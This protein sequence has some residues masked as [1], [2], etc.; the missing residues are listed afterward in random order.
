MP[1]AWFLAPGKGQF[2][3]EVSCRSWSGLWGVINFDIDD[4]CSQYLEKAS[5]Y[6]SMVSPFTSKKTFIDGHFEYSLSVMIVQTSEGYKCEI[7]GILCI[8]CMCVTMYVD[9]WCQ[10][11]TTQVPWWSNRL[12]PVPRVVRVRV[13]RV[14]SPVAVRQC[15]GCHDSH[16]TV[17]RDTRTVLHHS[18]CGPA[19]PRAVRAG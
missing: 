8:V 19:W 2:S 4:L 12:V 15:P 18:F 17:T 3:C 1:C 13:F 14:Q 16:V 6:T 10:N 11:W 9:G 7:S 5:Y